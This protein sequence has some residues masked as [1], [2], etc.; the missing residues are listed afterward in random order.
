MDAV[1]ETASL[2]IFVGKRID[3]GSFVS[4]ISLALP[5]TRLDQ[6][7][8]ESRF[9]VRDSGGKTE[10]FALTDWSQILLTAGKAPPTKEKLTTKKAV[11]NAASGVEMCEQGIYDSLKVIEDFP[12]LTFLLD[13][14]H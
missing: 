7:V 13:R 12:M 6:L 11:S 9:S 10:S 8:V 2:A 1:F 4:F 14:K 3:F 5:L